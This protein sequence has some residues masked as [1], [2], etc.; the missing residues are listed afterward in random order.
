MRVV[1]YPKWKLPGGIHLTEGNGPTSLLQLMSCKSSL[2]QLMS[3]NSSYV[4]TI[5][6][7]FNKIQLSV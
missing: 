4:K 7:S 5:T 6:C 2:L 3:C 1:D